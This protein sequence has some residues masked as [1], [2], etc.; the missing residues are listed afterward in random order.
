MAVYLL[1]NMFCDKVAWKYDMYVRNQSDR[2]TNQPILVL[3]VF[4]NNQPINHNQQSTY[5]R[6]PHLHSACCNIISLRPLIIEGIAHEEGRI[7]EHVVALRRAQIENLP[8]C[9]RKQTFRL[10]LRSSCCFSRPPWYRTC[11]TISRPTRCCYLH[12]LSSS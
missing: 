5:L 12:K 11:G 1:H 3:V 10:L 9:G 7:G 4:N 6:A 8:W 2:P